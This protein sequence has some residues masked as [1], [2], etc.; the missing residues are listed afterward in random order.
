MASKDTDR[1]ID[2]LLGASSSP[3]ASTLA[4]R[5]KGDAGP[6]PPRRRSSSTLIP[7]AGAP[8]PASTRSDSA[9]ASGI[10]VPSPTTAPTSPGAPRATASSRARPPS[11]HQRAWPWGDGHAP[12]PLS[13]KEESSEGP[14]PFRVVRLK[15]QRTDVGSDVFR[16]TVA[17]GEAGWAPAASSS[18]AA[19]P[20]SDSARAEAARCLD[21]GFAALRE[22]Q[23]ALAATEWERAAELDPDNKTISTN[24]KRLR[25]KRG[26]A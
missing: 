2:V 15:E 20:S 17:Q 3:E 1:S 10:R 8:P 21:R 23:Y 11:Q 18:R 19:T 16:S 6:T 12:S 14:D 13:A 24:L 25:E 5:A 7:I 4:Q 9:L 22:G 26:G